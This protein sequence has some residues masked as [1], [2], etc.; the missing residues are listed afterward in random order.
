MAAAG[1]TPVFAFAHSYGPVGDV[2]SRFAVA[3]RASGGRVFV[4]RYGYLSDAKLDAIGAIA[5]GTLKTWVRQDRLKRGVATQQSTGNGG[6][7]VADLSA[8]QRLTQAQAENQ[9]LRERNKALESA[10]SVLAEE[11]DILRKATK[12][13]AAETNW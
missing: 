1:A 5:R 13:F 2:A 9:A 4:N 6:T 10:N 7:P 8:E 3:W 11:R 12:Y